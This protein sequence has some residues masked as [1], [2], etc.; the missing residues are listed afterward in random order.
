MKRIKYIFTLM[1]VG[2]LM[3]MPVF[4]D[5]SNTING[6]DNTVQPNGNGPGGGGFRHGWLGGGGQG[7]N[8]NGQ[9][10]NRNGQGLNPMKGNGNG[11]VCIMVS[12]RLS[13]VQQRIS[14]HQ[15]YQ[16]RLSNWE[17]KTNQQNTSLANLRAQWDTNLNGQFSALE[18]KETTSAQKQAVSDFETAVKNAIATRRSAVDTAMTDFRTSVKGL[19]TTQGQGTDSDLTTYENAIESDFNTANQSCQATSPDDAAIS[20]TLQSSLQAARS[21]FQSSQQSL[22]KAGGNS[23]IQALITTRKAAIDQAMSDFKSAME[24]ARTNLKAAF[25]NNTNTDSSGTSPN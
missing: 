1:L 25:P 21:Q 19:I 24:T 22:P 20:S 7:Q 18:A 11:N 13:Q 23:D 17:Q 16:S 9:G 3:A 14:Q 4:A 2:S 5:N 15:N 12:N 8:P 10:P 6:S